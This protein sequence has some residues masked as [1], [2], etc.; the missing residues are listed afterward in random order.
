MSDNRLLL[1]GFKPFGGS[2]VNPSEKAAQALDGEVI[3]GWE[4]T[5][6]ILPVS[7]REGPAAL[8]A[9]LVDL[10]PGAVVCLGEATRRP[11]ISI[12][13][14]AIN[15]LDFCIPDNCG[16]TIT[17]EPVIIGAPAAYFTTLPVRSM[18]QAMLSAG[19]PAELSLTA[20]AFLCN[21]LF[22]FLLHHLATSGE[23]LPAGFI[24]LPVLPEQAANNP[25]LAASMNLDTILQGLRAGIAIIEPGVS[26]G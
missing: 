19:I 25:A 8:L 3:G 16:E 4:I 14:V 24:H 26:H 23:S 15:W 10:K 17:D 21:Q 20:G 1:T 11:A 2:A 22:F 18:L 12:E 5:S 9:A 13:R 6:R 7:R